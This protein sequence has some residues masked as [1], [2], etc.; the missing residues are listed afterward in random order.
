MIKTDYL[1]VGLL[2]VILF[3]GLQLQ[4]AYSSN[5]TNS[6]SNISILCSE[7]RI[8]NSLVQDT[9]VLPSTVAGQS[10][11]EAECNMGTN[12]TKGQGQGNQNND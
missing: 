2:N 3:L 4:L 12:I 9:E 1:I 5:I 6:N 7:I 8:L 11:T 10:T